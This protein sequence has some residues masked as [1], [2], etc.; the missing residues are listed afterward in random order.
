M[1]AHREHF[2]PIPV[3]A[4]GFNPRGDPH[5][6][7]N[8]T[9]TLLPSWIRTWTRWIH[10]CT[11]RWWRKGSWIAEFVLVGGEGGEG[12]PDLQ[13]WRC[14]GARPSPSPPP[15]RSC[16][17]ASTVVRV[18]PPPPRGAPPSARGATARRAT[19]GQ[20]SHCEAHHCRPRA[21]PLPPAE[22]G[23]G[24]RRSRR[25]REG[26]HTRERKREQGRP[27]GR[28]G[29][30]LRGCRSERETCGCWGENETLSAVYI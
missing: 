18:P 3:P 25:G 2:F 16:N 11:R 8:C 30:R 14:S 19:A 17:Q 5:P 9:P 1:K 13:C 4:R 20:G 22:G 15:H 24:S 7:I 12:P 23:G 29:G 26:D 21:P 28:E 27:H 6:R 10:I